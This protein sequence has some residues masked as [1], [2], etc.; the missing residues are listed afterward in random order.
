MHRP[1]GS[2]LQQQETETA[3]RVQALRCFLRPLESSVSA[4]RSILLCSNSL[5]GIQILT[6]VP[7]TQESVLAQGIWALLYTA[8]AWGRTT[9]LH[10]G[11]PTRA[12]ATRASR[13]MKKLTAWPTLQGRRATN[14]RYQ[15][16]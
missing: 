14:G 2:R 1:G 16:I 7:A 15:L 10:A 8:A 3:A 4:V 12:L 11:H 13:G 5:S 6:R 9:S